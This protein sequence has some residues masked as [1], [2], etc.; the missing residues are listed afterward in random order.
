MLMPDSV[1]TLQPED[2]PP[3]PLE[4]L[5]VPLPIAE[6]HLHEGGL[7]SFGYGL[8]IISF[9]EH[10]DR[11]QKYFI[12]NSLDNISSSKTDERQLKRIIW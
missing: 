8:L 12:C 3:A 4:I 1:L 10:V 5:K 2:L 11:I 6:C 9:V 7:P